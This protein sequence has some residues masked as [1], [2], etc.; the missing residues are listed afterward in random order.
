MTH[1]MAS[2]GE[3]SAGLTAQAWVQEPSYSESRASHFQMRDFLGP[4]TLILKDSNL[5]CPAWMG[6]AEGFSSLPP[7]FREV[8]KEGHPPSPG[9]CQARGWAEPVL[10]CGPGSHTPGLCLS[11]C[12]LSL[13]SIREACASRPAF[14]DTLNP[15]MDNSV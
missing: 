15:E 6:K 4:L 11:H 12:P 3:A 10:T 8:G 9:L 2:F 14:G 13:S 1:V 7:G 5:G